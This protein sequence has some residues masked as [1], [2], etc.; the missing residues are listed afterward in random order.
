[1]V[2]LALDVRGD[3]AR[4]VV[5]DVAAGDRELGD[6][7][8]GDLRVATGAGVSLSDVSASTKPAS[9]VTCVSTP[10]LRSA[11]SA[12]GLT[13]SVEEPLAAE[14]VSVSSSP[15]AA[16]LKAMSQRRRG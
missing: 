15:Q 16:K 6:A 5:L 13:V 8:G 12:A 10:L 2:D 3:G 4:G 9:S 7:A 1:M 11:T 14:F